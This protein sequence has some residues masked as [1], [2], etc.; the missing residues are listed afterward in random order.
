MSKLTT[1]AWADALELYQYS[2]TSVAV[3]RR[4]HEEWWL[5]VAAIMLGQTADPRGWPSLDPDEGE[6]ERRDDPLFPFAEAPTAPEDVVRFRRRVTEIPRNSAHSLLVMLSIPGL[7]A[8]KA[9][10]FDHDRPEME[11]RADL[12]ISRFPDGT[13]FYSNIGWKGDNPDFYEQP[14]RL[15]DPFSRYGWD[16]GLIAVNNSEVAMIWYFDPT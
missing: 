9:P 11:R 1:E 4:E 7:D 2:Y 10:E 3:G 5:D 16:A 15:T 14:V 8:T 12:I 6:F 13:R